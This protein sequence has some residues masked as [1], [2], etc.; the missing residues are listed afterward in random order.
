MSPSECVDHIIPI[1]CVPDLQWEEENWAA[2][3]WSCHSYKTTKEP[4]FKWAPDYERVVVCGLPGTG[5]STWARARGAPYFDADELGLEGWGPIIAAR[6][7]WIREHRGPVTVIVA[8]TMSASIV[9]SQL[10]GTV[11]HETTVYRAA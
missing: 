9:A 11:R 7:A 2:L 8:S 4:R 1:A 6:D 5:K 10:K 3:C